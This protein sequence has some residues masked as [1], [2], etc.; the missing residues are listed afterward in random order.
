[1]IYFIDFDYTIADTSINSVCSGNYKEKQ[2]LIPQYKI[3]KVA[4]DF[5][6]TERKQFCL[7]S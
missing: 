5:S 2:K 3:Y 1:M 7:Y 6:R 4:V